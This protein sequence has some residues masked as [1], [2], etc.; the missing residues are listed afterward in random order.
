MTTLTDPVAG[1]ASKCSNQQN[2]ASLDAACSLRDA[3]AAAAAVNQ[4]AGSMA[5][6]VT[7]ATSL[8]TVDNH[9]TLTL[10][11]AALTLPA[12]TTVQGLTAGSGYS[13]TN[14]I[15]IS[16]NAHA[17]FTADLSAT[18]SALNNLTL[19]KGA[20]ALVNLG[21]LSVSQCTFV[22]NTYT[23]G[24]AI[25]NYGPLVVSAS[26]FTGNSSSDYGG[27]IY[28]TGSDGGY[29][30]LVPT[31][32][33]LTV[34]DSTFQGNSSSDGGAV[35]IG[36]KSVGF[37]DSSTFTG[38]RAARGGAV[39]LN[40]GS[41]LSRITNSILTDD[42]GSSECDGFGCGNA[43]RG[44]LFLGGASKSGVVTM[45][46]TL[47]TGEVIT[48]NA[49]YGPASNG[50]S[51]AS[52]FGA[53]ISSH[54]YGSLSAQGFGP[55][56]LVEPPAATLTS[57]TFNDPSNSFTVA[58]LPNSVLSGTGNMVAVG[59]AAA[60]LSTLGS[61]GG[62]TQTVLP[63]PGSAALCAITPVSPAG[64]DERGQPRTTAFGAALCQDS[65]A[66]QTSY[67]LAFVQQ[68][69]ATTAGATL[70]PSPSVQVFESGRPLAQAN[71][72]VTMKNLSGTLSGS[73][74]A[75]TGA[76]GLASFANLS[77]PRVQ[78]Q[79]TLTAFLAV[80][81]NS[82]SVTSNPFEVAPQPTASLAGNSTFPLTAV[83][84]RSSREFLFTNTGTSRI[85]ISALSAGTAPE[86]TQTNTC[87]LTLL[88][89]ASC[90][91]TV[92]FQPV[93]AGTR[94]GTLTLGSDASGYTQTLGLTG[95]AV[96][97]TFTLVDNT[98]GGM[99]TAIAVNAGGAG[100]GVLK[101]TSLNGFAGSV[102]LVCVAQGPAPIGAT[103]TVGSPAV[104][105]AGGSTTAT[106]ILATTA[107][108]L[109]AGLPL[110]RRVVP[111]GLWLLTL[112]LMAAAG[113]RSA[114]RLSRVGSLLLLLL[115]LS[116][117]LGG[118]GGPVSIPAGTPAGTYTYTVT[119]T[120]GTVTATQSI[121]VTV[122]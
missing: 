60:N 10:G 122:R 19:T 87:G 15:S 29:A 47:S 25:Y 3:L 77:I 106:V 84:A 48:V 109:H 89:G 63:L 73:T 6:T 115:S 5:V 16:G 45:T 92:T 17:I 49:A 8:A 120:G 37:I 57:I 36:Q 93:V 74:T 105:T 51:L 53:Y 104:L 71:A 61:Y 86:W 101:L 83:S 27:A 23:S 95:T 62:P 12:Y 70:A 100:T 13:L 40:N 55:T 68:P 112:V 99:S 2:G 28:S 94:T 26:T 30:G 110:P 118:C 78:A 75:K 103:C 18:Q 4:P 54:Y 76:S 79:D 20:P 9:G 117:G 41:S 50:A 67:S 91:V 42:T 113:L 35:Y 64:T 85:T 31:T 121:T 39:F 108:V 107:R 69:G 34:A 33:N 72:P 14:L 52:Y 38:N 24:G 96:V 102:A 44:F 58:P 65:G 66:V 7:F 56:L 119:A 81:A 11:T 32:K 46:A 98:S 116:V 90:V 43:A 59:S 111:V 1:T 88:A 22:N 82:V 21:S 114:K 97:P 80:G